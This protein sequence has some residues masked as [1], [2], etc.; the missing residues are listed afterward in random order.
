MKSE[1]IYDYLINNCVGYDNRI[2]ANVLMT[3][4]G[5]KDNKTFRSYIQD[6]RKNPDYEKLVGSEAGHNGGYYIVSNYDEYKKTIDHHYLRAM[7]MLKTYGIMKEK[8]LKR[9]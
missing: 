2:K 1:L 8:Y 5:I 9:K 3:L 4:F 7:E 6:I